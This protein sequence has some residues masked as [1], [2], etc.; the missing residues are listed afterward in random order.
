MERRFFIVGCPSSAAVHDL[1]WA[2][3]QKGRHFASV[4]HEQTA[5]IWKQH[6]LDV[7]DMNAVQFCGPNPHPPLLGG[8]YVPQ[9]AAA[10]GSTSLK[11]SFTSL[12][13][14]WNVASSSLDVPLRPLCT[15]LCG[16]RCKKEGILRVCSMSRQL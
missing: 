7:V 3:M 11:S 8:Y 9:G 13:F 15:I 14:W 1:V 5:L 4:Q 12:A 16:Q 2:T 10:C 6:A